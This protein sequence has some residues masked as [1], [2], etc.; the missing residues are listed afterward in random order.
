MKKLISITLLLLFSI[1]S[2][3][4]NDVTRF[5]GIPIDG[6]KSEMTRK[7]KSKGFEIDATGKFLNGQFNGNNVNLFIGTNN[8]KVCRI[9]LCDAFP[10]NESDVKIR[11]NTL[12]Q[13]FE[14]NDNYISFDD[15]RIPEKENI[16]YEITV[17][18]KRY[19]AAF[20]QIP[21]GMDSTAIREKL[22]SY[23]STKFTEEQLSNS[24]EETKSQIS[25]ATYNYLYD[26]FSK[27]PVWFMIS[28][29]GTDYNIIMYYDNEFNRANG[30][31]L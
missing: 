9:M 29:D 20:Y 25:E 3:A 15:C 28:N 4:Q 24:T 11:F 14:N 10:L 30:E 17:N 27:R 13:Q 31:D 18:K 19:E 21:A 22:Q 23:L 16:S 1:A 2:H 26:F 12:C 7:L 8:N 6:S 5:L